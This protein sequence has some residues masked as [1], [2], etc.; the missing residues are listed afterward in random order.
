M[1]GADNESKNFAL[2]FDGYAGEVMVSREKYKE[3]LQLLKSKYAKL[4]L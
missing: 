3:V 2:I 1:F 4:T